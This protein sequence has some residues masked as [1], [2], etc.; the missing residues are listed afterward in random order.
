MTDFWGADG[1]ARDRERFLRGE[2]AVTGLRAPILNSW[3]RCAVMGLSPDR[4]APPYQADADLENRLARAA[5]PVLQRLETELAGA[6]VAVVLADRHGVILR[7]RSGERALYRHLEA[8]RL[9]PGFTYTEEYVG[10]HGI[11][12]ALEER[13]DFH[14]FGAEHFAACLRP[15][16]S[17]GA[18]VRDALSG[19][20]EGVIGLTCLC[21]DADTDMAARVRQAADAV[22]LRLLED[23][24]VREQ[25]L[26]QEALQV[27]RR[28]DVPLPA[29]SLSALTDSDRNVLREKATELIS[30]AGGTT[31]QVSLSGGRT[32]ALVCRPVAGT[33]GE[34]GVVVKLS[35]VGDAGGT[36]Q[37][38]VPAPSSEQPLVAAP[39]D[40]PPGEPGPA[41]GA[42][43][44]A[45][46][47]WLLAVGHPELG[48]LAMAARE[49]LELLY[50][51]S[52]RIGTTLDV[53]RTAEELAEVVVPRFAD[54]VT[55]DLLEPVL[56]GEEAV[57]R[58]A[59]LQRAALGAHLAEPPFP[60]VGKRISFA[61]SAPQARC[62]AEGQAVLEPD[63]QAVPEWLA[64]DP[65]RIRE[66]VE[67]GVHSL[68][69]VPL[70]T[71]R[72][73]LGLAT[74]YR[75]RES[76][77]F[78][79]DD[80]H[81]AEELIA[82][83]AICVDN[84]R[85]FTREQ[86]VA[87]TL[88]RS[89]LPGVLPEQTAVEV[90]HRYLP[91]Q[92]AVGGVGGDWFDIIPL[93]GGRVALVV[94]DV[95]G[96]GLH[97]AVTMGR[98]RTAVHNFAT[99]DM[100]PDE[101]LGRVDDLVIALGQEGT[102]RPGGDDIIGATCLYAVYDPVSQRCTMA[103]AGHP[104]PAVVD[105]G[106]AV[107]F[108]DLP[109]GPPLGLGGLPFETA[110]LDL[111]EGSQL[112]LY[113]DGLIEDREWDIDT[114]L[115]RLRAVLSHADRAPE[116]TC[117]AVLRELPGPHSSDDVTLLVARTRALGAEHTACWD[118]PA[119]PAAISGVREAAVRQLTEWGLEDCAFTTEL[120]L[121]ELA[122]NAIRHATGPVQVRLL[123][124]R[125]LICEVSDGSSTSPHLR[126]ATATD[127]GGR[128]L[129]LVAQ[130]AQR[131]GT[132]YTPRGK[133]IWAEQPLS[134]AAEFPD[135]SLW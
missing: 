125:V 120:L 79:E 89:L 111:P 104:P 65:D 131:W 43:T 55:V 74:F 52:I 91:A 107:R 126:Q 37:V 16:V 77:P 40:E 85:R 123:R 105:P 36:P 1:V 34:E 80:L 48:Q 51:A 90:A 66:I 95:V 44:A 70:R 133:V 8:V 99:L 72:A 46:D 22:G 81:L 54:I 128:G 100:A 67:Y 26:L 103:R 60:P 14:V 17:A 88:Q 124:D 102:S 122:T 135:P 5:A 68:I 39:P 27:E 115:E 53:A 101:L 18:V 92:I 4:I 10:T 2:S 23:R 38:M 41:D 121:S 13:Q 82:R 32:A 11:A 45:P 29:S 119:D 25:A 117:E 108:P 127:E 33:S 93:S 87:L 106:G 130:L 61:S 59:P 113:T 109:A 132:R 50:D 7:C 47:E 83:V 42:A 98:L 24:R 86:T 110:E 31:V 12:T 64:Q 112:V 15:F 71:R 84:A 3:R 49:R 96:H 73:S 30:A 21:G 9:A 118:V 28:Q 134:P 6:R 35:L 62:F 114:A 19:S 97:A 63:V 94:G 58:D 57:A 78:E 69:A 76:R 116:Q 129:F 56:R 20:L 75:C